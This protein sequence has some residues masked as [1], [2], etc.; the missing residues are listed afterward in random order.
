ML[1]PLAQ[2]PE[3][4]RAR[5]G[6]AA[7]IPLLPEEVRA[8]LS[9]SSASPELDERDEKIAPCSSRGHHSPSLRPRG[10]QHR[11]AALRRRFG[12]R[13]T[14]ELAAY[15]A[16]HGIGMARIGNDPP[17]GA[18]G[19][20]DNWAVRTTREEPISIQTSPASLYTYAKE[21]RS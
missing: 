13:S 9:G 19:R 12:M 5:A 2:A 8:V 15:L 16:R 3:P 21:L 11:L 4:W 14:T 17:P 1:L 20:S 18:L 6:E 7:L 10:V